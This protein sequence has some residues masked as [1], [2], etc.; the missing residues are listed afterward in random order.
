[1]D[2][3]KVERKNPESHIAWRRSESSRTLEKPAQ[4]VVRFVS[5]IC[6]M[7]IELL[8]A[9][10]NDGLEVLASALDLRLSGN[11]EPPGYSRKLISADEEC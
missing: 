8:A 2:R 7:F 3:S 11:E 10:S 9:C 4:H 1:M 6:T 5:V